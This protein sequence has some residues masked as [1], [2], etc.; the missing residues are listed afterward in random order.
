M[1]S[2]S[3]Y[4]P[5][6]IASCRDRFEAQLSAYT[7]LVDGSSAP[8]VPEFERK[9]CRAMLLALDNCF[10]TRSR[11]AEGA[12]GN[13]LN[14]VR[15]LCSSIMTNRGVLKMDPQI[16]LTP[17]TSVLGFAAGDQIHLTVRDFARLS[18][19]FFAAIEAKF[20]TAVAA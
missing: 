10:S 12:N 16:E 13:P 15:V 19:A 17:G 8:N 2:V 5:T 20:T 14:E 11:T 9:Y 4:S 7:Q 3:Y 1:A 18:F 6:Y